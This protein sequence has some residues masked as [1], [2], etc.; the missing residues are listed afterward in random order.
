MTS[1]FSFSTITNITNPNH[2]T[3]K[4]TAYNKDENRNDNTN[5]QVF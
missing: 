2:A 5:R 3:I 1:D 4:T